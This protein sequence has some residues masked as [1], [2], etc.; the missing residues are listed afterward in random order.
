MIALRINYK[1][2]ILSLKHT[3]DFGSRSFLVVEF[4]YKK[5][6]PK[7]NFTNFNRR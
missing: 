6:D 5:Y 4:I 7:N 1:T 3:S 2:R